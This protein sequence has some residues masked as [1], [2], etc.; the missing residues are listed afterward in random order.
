MCEVT[1]FYE[2]AL[3]NFS[4][5]EKNNIA[6]IF[7][8]WSNQS[9]NGHRIK[10]NLLIEHFLDPELISKLLLSV[11]N[12]NLSINNNDIELLENHYQDT[13]R[14]N[15]LRGGTIKGNIPNIVGT[16]IN[17]STFI[18]ELQKQDKDGTIFLHDPQEIENFVQSLL[19]PDNNFFQI[20][21]TQEKTSLKL[22]RYNIWVTWDT[23]SS[24]EP[25]A[26]RQ[27]ESPNEIRL[28]LALAADPR[29]VEEDLILL[30]YTKNFD[31]FR[32]TIADAQVGSY[33]QPP[34]ETF[35]D[36][37]LT[38]PCYLEL[39]VFFPLYLAE[40]SKYSCERRPEGLHKPISIDHVITS[41]SIEELS[42]SSQ[43]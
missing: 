20:F 36:H 31:I 40:Y 27:T 7:N 24:K 25:F 28:C 1:T 38:C 8:L 23:D 26:F 32:P 34:P 41:G 17:K 5:E 37:G 30:T 14:K 29:F 9:S 35:H 21:K 12:S 16:V 39:Q 6:E 15:L 43:K 4:L 42:Y 10:D 33:F 19:E 22:K 13:C 18:G 3:E 2:L 11:M